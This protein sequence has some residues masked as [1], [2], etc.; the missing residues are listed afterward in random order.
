MT[1]VRF[2][3]SRLMTRPVHLA[4]IFIS[5]SRP[6]LI[7]SK[8]CPTFAISSRILSKVTVRMQGHDRLRTSIPT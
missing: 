7:T 6:K 3:F 8:F 4:K 2:R 5:Q 1:K